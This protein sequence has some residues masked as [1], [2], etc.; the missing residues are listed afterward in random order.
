MI[1]VP[2]P[3][4]KALLTLASVINETD[5]LK[6]GRTVGKLGLCGLSANELNRLLYEGRV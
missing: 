3:A 5:Y 4:T 1:N 2:T 6:E